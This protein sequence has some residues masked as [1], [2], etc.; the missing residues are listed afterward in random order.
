MIQRRGFLHCSLAAAALASLPRAFGAGNTAWQ[1]RAAMPLALQEI[2]PALQ[3]Q[4]IHVAGGLTPLADGKTGASDAHLAYNIAKDRW[5]T[6]ASLPAARHH[7]ALAF[8]GETLFAL[9][10]FGTTDQGTWSMNADSWSYD[11]GADRWEKRA[12]APEP[13]GESVTLASGELIHVIG[14]RTPMGERNAGW[15][16]HTDSSR[17]LA[18]DAAGNRWIRLAPPGHARNSAAGAVIDGQLYIVGGRTVAGGNVAALEIYD[19][20]EDRWRPGAPMPLAQGG[21]A[22]AAVDGRLVALG[23]EYFGAKGYGVLKNVW[24]YAPQRDA[25]TALPDMATPR[26]GLGAVS[27]GTGIYAIGGA[28]QVGPRGTSNLVEMLDL[29]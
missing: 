11:S 19:A 23:G 6:R 17:H 9:G 27:D 2:Y 14:G 16:D 25:W 13:H 1:P 18:F 26:H 28:T 5:D 10:G 3:G 12:P 7:V 29:D 21:L 22:A 15:M 24:Q 4:R 20:R 8:C